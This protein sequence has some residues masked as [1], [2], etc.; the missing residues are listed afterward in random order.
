MKKYAN[1]L[2]KAA[3]TTIM[4][5]A[6]LF[7]GCGS[8]TE[9]TYLDEIKA[10]DYVTLSD[11][12]GIEVTQAQ[13]EI[14]DEYRDSYID[15]MLCLNPDRAVI[16]GDTV[17]IDYVGTLDGVAFDGGTAS[18]QNLT[19]GSGQFIEGFEE[20]LIGVSAGE[21]VDLDL[22][23]P[24][25]YHAA[26]LAGKAVV[27]TVTVNTIMAAEPQELN[28]AYVQKLDIGLNTVDE[29][30]QFVYDQLYAE[31]VAAYETKVETAVVD[32]LMQNCE[33]KKEL[34]QAMV[35]RYA[36]SLT[37]NLTTQASSYGVTL[38]DFMLLY[39][40]MDTETYTEEIR[41]QAELSVKQYLI[42]Q[43]IAD[44]EKVD[45][46]DE[47]LQTKI[48]ELAANAG[49]ATVEEFKEATQ[50]DTRD[51]REYLMGQRVMD[52]LRENA[53]VSE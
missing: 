25:D 24:E 23:F 2:K 49:Y 41:A 26:E 27:F 35:D 18:G 15:Y 33:F 8:D 29:Y 45:I 6:V 40:G 28:D 46:T 9:K 32:V 30:K 31:E 21:T 14:T 37:T 44:K 5:A 1:L 34:P 43:A 39:Y 16:E 11:Y 53:V 38:D 48:E 17:N 52:L 3:L 50:I 10:G 12:K 42:L 19:I 13:P 7:T 47:E 51:Y 22:T 20:G 4:A 36:K